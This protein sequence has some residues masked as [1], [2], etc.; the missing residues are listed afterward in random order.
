M[1]AAGRS[2]I[3]RAYADDIHIL[4]SPEDTAAAYAYLSGPPSSPASLASVGLEVVPHK[5]DVWAP[6]LSH[7]PHETSSAP[8][9]TVP[10]GP[11]AITNLRATLLSLYPAA[12][13]AQSFTTDTER[14]PLS[15]PGHLVCGVP[16]GTHLYAENALRALIYKSAAIIETL[17]ELLLDLI[18][19]PTERARLLV[20]CIHPRIV[21]MGRTLPPDL[22]ATLFSEFDNLMREAYTRHPDAS[23]IRPMSPLPV[24][25]ILSLPLRAGG[26]A[27]TSMSLISPSA[28]TGSY[29]LCYPRMLHWTP[30]L[31][32]APSLEDTT[33]DWPH[34]VS[35]RDSYAAIRAEW[36]RSNNPEHSPGYAI[37]PPTLRSVDRF[38]T[39]SSF[40]AHSWP[41]AQRELSAILHRRKWLDIYSV[42][43][44]PAARARMLSAA[45]SRM[46]HLRCVP[47]APHQGHFSYTRPNDFFADMAIDFM[48]PPRPIL[49]HPCHLCARAGVANPTIH[50]SENPQHYIQCTRGGRTTHH[51]AIVLQVAAMMES[52]YPPHTVTADVGRGASAHTQAAR[53]YSPL[54]TPDITVVP[55]S[56][57]NGS[58]ELLCVEIKTFT[59]EA[60]THV[61]A[62]SASNALTPH[63][64]LCE[65]IVSDYGLRSQPRRFQGSLY[66]L[67]I[68]LRGGMGNGLGPLSQDS[69]P[70][71]LKGGG[72]LLRLLTTLSRERDFPS[73]VASEGDANSAP[74]RTPVLF[75]DFWTRRI[76]FTLRK[77]IV[78]HVLFSGGAAAPP[79]YRGPHTP[80]PPTPATPAPHNPGDTPRGPTRINRPRSLHHNTDVHGVPLGTDRTTRNGTPGRHGVPHAAHSNTR[81]P[82]DRPTA[83]RTPPRV[84]RPDSLSAPNP[85]SI[86]PLTTAP[87][88]PTPPA[89]EPP[90]RTTPTSAPLPL[91]P[92]L[93]DIDMDMSPPPPVRASRHLTP[94]R[95]RLDRAQCPLPFGNPPPRRSPRLRTET[96]AS[97]L[98]EA[99]HTPPESGPEPDS[100]TDLPPALITP[101][102]APPTAA[103]PSESA[104]D[105]QAQAVGFL[106]TTFP[107][108]FLVN[109]HCANDPTSTSEGLGTDPQA[110]QPAPPQASCEAPG[111]HSTPTREDPLRGGGPGPGNQVPGPTHPAGD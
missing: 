84:P 76:A 15:H 83:N 46:T 95:T 63:R 49:G 53:A 30:T 104:Q 27:L 7:L 86:S 110:S 39:L 13:L 98:G 45:L 73:F 16:V 32:S 72:D 88:P 74:G 57:P 80:R 107:Q 68:D 38:P 103:R 105:F 64:R 29:A 59:A 78:D 61:A 10:G 67:T 82:S 111:A 97:P 109:Q 58:T 62:G 5:C 40:S 89:S 42:M 36:D 77:S 35:L 17:D 54:H 52:V 101:G 70:R 12:V 79:L 22:C 31:R 37:V 99:D 92:P 69:S 50:S 94:P 44:V 1:I 2:V 9:P 106:A 33:C 65:K 25:E 23:H 56:N 51:D 21:H 26:Y 60:P 71:L 81:A 87:R 66:A 24:D 20:S 19:A 102:G 100:D 8:F 48:V 93:E 85:T 43:E 96:P 34:R 4:G 55:Q 108:A 91:G 47:S 90:P 11:E 41:H 28:F 14:R 18:E 3:I 6:W 75:R